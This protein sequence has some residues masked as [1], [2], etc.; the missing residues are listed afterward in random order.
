MDSTFVI[1][2]RS[3]CQTNNRQQDHRSRNDRSPVVNNDQFPQSDP[4]ASRESAE[5]NDAEI[6]LI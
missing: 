5:D 1:A 2:R 3:K 6:I 4:P